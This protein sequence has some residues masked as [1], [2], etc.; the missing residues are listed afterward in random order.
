MSGIENDQGWIKLHRK[1]NRWEWKDKPLTV[2]LF[3]HLLL[4]ASH[5]PSNWRGVVIPQGSLMAG[6]KKLSHSTGLSERQVRTA[7]NHLISTNEV[8]IKATKEYSIISI[9]N[10]N[11]YQEIDQQNANERPSTDQAPTT[12]KNDNNDKKV[13][14]IRI[15]SVESC[16]S[17]DWVL[18]DEWGDWA[19]ERGMKPE[20]VM[21]SWPRFRDNFISKGIK[22]ADWKATW[23]TWVR[24]SIEKGWN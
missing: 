11:I 19:I 1:L 4:R 13:K 15:R 12:Y 16:L 23:R 9:T 17:D 10:W 20:Q 5:K 2:A 21:K 22:R 7:L 6:R 24:N 8:T 14:N 18:P 3:V